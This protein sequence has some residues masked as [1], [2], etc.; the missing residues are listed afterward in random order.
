MKNFN[1]DNRAGRRD[2]GRFERRD[3]RNF[4][5]RDSGRF[6]RRDSTR[7][8]ERKIMHSVICDKCGQECEVPFKPTKGKPIYCSECFRNEGGSSSRNKPNQFAEEFQKINEKLDRI[9]KEL[10]TE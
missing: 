7:N 10:E 8:F 2:S 6:E 4:E 9:L 3:S 5:R 1:R